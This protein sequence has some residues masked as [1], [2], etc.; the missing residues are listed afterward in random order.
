VRVGAARGLIGQY[1][2]RHERTVASLEESAP[3]ARSSTVMGA[4]TRCRTYAKRTIWPGQCYGSAA[5]V[6]PSGRRSASRCCRR[7]AAGRVGD[8]PNKTCAPDPLERGEAAVGRSLVQA[9]ADEA[10]LVE[11]AD[12]AS[13]AN[14]ALLDRVLGVVQRAE[15]PVAMCLQ[16]AAVR[17][18]QLLERVGF[19]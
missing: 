6:L 18:H 12:T 7:W 4:G 8:H 9:R 16:L 2:G 11:T 1:G 15:H 5:A 10:A 19:A 17:R 14:E 3:Q 13:R